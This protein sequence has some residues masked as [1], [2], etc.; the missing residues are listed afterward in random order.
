MVTFAPAMVLDFWE[1][2]RRDSVAELVLASTGILTTLAV[3]SIAMFKVWKY[4]NLS[5]ALHHSPAVLLYSNTSFLSQWGPL[6]I[7]FKAI[8][9]YAFVFIFTQVLSKALFLAFGQR[10]GL[11]Q[12]V[13]FLVLD[14]TLLVGYSILKPFM[15]HK[16]NAFNIGIATINCLNSLL[17]FFFTG[18][19]GLPVCCNVFYKPNFCANMS[20]PL[21]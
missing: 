18:A 4:G 15:D 19:L 10:N 8:C 17:L 3:L 6:Y 20:S 12:A 14:L 11:I 2:K 5:I 13:A 1:L 16:T 7:P 21:L 9:F